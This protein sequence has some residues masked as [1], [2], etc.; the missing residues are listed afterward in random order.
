MP[1][2]P[3]AGVRLAVTHL[4]TQVDRGRRDQ[5]IANVSLVTA[6]AAVLVGVGLLGASA[7]RAPAAG[8]ASGAA[9]PAQ[10]GWRGIAF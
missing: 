4:R 2:D 3:R 10:P 9:R 6:G 8:A 1:L 7:L 5:T